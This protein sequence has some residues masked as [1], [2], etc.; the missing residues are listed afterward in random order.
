MSRENDIA[1]PVALDFL[2]QQQ[3]RILGEFAQTR[4]GMTVLLAI[5]QRLDATVGG[6]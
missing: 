3:L 1:D 4:A 5:V 6:R 2:A